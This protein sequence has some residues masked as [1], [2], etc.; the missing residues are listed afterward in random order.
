ML[1]YSSCRLQFAISKW[2]EWNFRFEAHCFYYLSILPCSGLM[3]SG[4]ASRLSGPGSSP[5]QGHRVVFLAKTLN[6]H[7]TSLYQDV[8]MGTGKS[9]V[10]SNPAMD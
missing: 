2:P 10:E 5:G 6:S 7:S 3:V 9:H 8:R 4:F 1:S